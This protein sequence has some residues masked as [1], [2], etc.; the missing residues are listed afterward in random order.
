MENLTQSLGVVKPNVAPAPLEGYKVVVLDETKGGTKFKALLNPTDKPLKTTAGWFKPKPSYRCFAVSTDL[1][2]CFDFNAQ[3]TLAAMY[4]Y[5]TIKGTV[6]YYIADPGPMAL[7]FQ[8]DPLRR[9]QDEIRKRVQRNILESRVNIDDIQSKFYHIKDKILPDP[10]ETQIRDFAGEFGMVIREIDMTYEIPDKWVDPGR[11]KE[12]FYLES[13]T[14]FIEEEKKRKKLEEEKDQLHHTHDLREIERGNEVKEE[15]HQGKIQDVKIKQDEKNTYHTVAMDDVKDSHQFRRDLPKRLLTAI[16][17][18][19]GS[20]NNPEALKKVADASIDVIKRVANEIQDPGQGFAQSQIASTTGGMKALI[21]NENGPFAEAKKLLTDI[22]EEIGK[23]S[24]DADDKK[25]MLACTTHL[26][27]EAQMEEK[28]NLETVKTSLQK[29]D[30]FLVKHRKILTRDLVK[31]VKELKEKF[32]LPEAS[33]ENEN[34]T[35]NEDIPSEE[36][37]EEEQK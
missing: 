28:A 3:I 27:A 22:I 34:S 15:V 17:K 36:S 29:L 35:P 1:N 30:D 37:R 12:D 25:S 26:L 20:I 21:S 10:V 14:A 33:A 4:Q 8:T 9:M 6:Y 31:K 19:I 11:K 32:N 24:I 16:D 5:F 18:A 13:V 2:L 7:A 23:A